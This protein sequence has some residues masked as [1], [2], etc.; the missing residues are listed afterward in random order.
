[1]RTP[2][3]ALRSLKKYVAASLGAEWEVRLED[4]DGAFDRPFARVNPTDRATIT[5]QGAYVRD[6]AQPFAVVCYTEPKLTP[7]EAGLEAGRVEEL[8]IT[9]FTVGTHQASF[10]VARGFLDA[11]HMFGRAHPMRVPLY[12]YDG[13]ALTEAVSEDAR[14]ARDFMRITNPPVVGRIDDPNDPLTYVVTANIQMSWSRVAA[15][16]SDG[17]SVESVR[18]EGETH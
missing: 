13:V 8:L 1:M 14:D 9:A 4:E 5:M 12:D 3:D 7:A 10:G 18:I 11:T 15:V 2:T 16:L 17:M 6:Y